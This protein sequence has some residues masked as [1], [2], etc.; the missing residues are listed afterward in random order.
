MKDF[1]FIFRG[2]AEQ[3][4]FSAEQMQQHMQKWFSWIDDLKARKIYV[5]GEPLDPRRQNGKRR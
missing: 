3:Y 2:A 5:S 4:E 1:M